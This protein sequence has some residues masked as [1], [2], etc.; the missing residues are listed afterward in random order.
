MNGN[1]KFQLASRD[2]CEGKQGGA[3]LDYGGWWRA[4]EGGGGIHHDRGSICW[5]AE[6]P[7]APGDRGRYF[8]WREINLGRRK[9]TGKEERERMRVGGKKKEKISRRGSA[10]QGRRAG[11][12]TLL[13]FTGSGIH[14]GT[15]RPVAGRVDKRARGRGGN[16]AARPRCSLVVQQPWTP[17]SRGVAAGLKILS[18]VVSGDF[19]C[20][21]SLRSARGSRHHLLL[22]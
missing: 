21:P 14:Q 8:V 5:A 16:L 13:P 10:N 22:L 20:T 17:S 19:C 6:A 1:R 7:S 4:G 15:S 18:H 3:R 9:G 2:S 11:G 12:K